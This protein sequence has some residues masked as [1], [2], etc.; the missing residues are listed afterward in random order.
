[1]DV[2]LPPFLRILH[3]L[4]SERSTPGLVV[5]LVRD[6]PLPMPRTHKRLSPHRPLEPVLAWHAHILRHEPPGLQDVLRAFVDVGPRDL[7]FTLRFAEEPQAH[8][9]RYPDHLGRLAC[10]TTSLFLRTT[11][12]RLAPHGAVDCRAAGANLTRSRACLQQD[13]ENVLRAMATLLHGIDRAH[14]LLRHVPTH[15]GLVQGSSAK[16]HGLT[17]GKCLRL[18]A[19]HCL[20]TPRFPPTCEILT[21]GNM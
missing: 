14:L 8:C 6:A 3:P 20:Q 4:R 17:S 7:P 19:G 1:M 11:R 2:S 12:I 13:L 21:H 18:G 15:H 5:L 16:P 9:L 10:A